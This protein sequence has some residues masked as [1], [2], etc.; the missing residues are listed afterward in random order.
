MSGSV[1]GE[2][3]RPGSGGGVGGGLGQEEGDR[4]GVDGKGINVWKREDGVEG[5]M[6]Y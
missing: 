4:G 2:G 3:V 5:G 1:G 6:G